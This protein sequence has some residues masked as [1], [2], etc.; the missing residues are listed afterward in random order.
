MAQS[1]PK[2]YPDGADLESRKSQGSQILV[3]LVPYADN[4]WNTAFQEAWASQ[5]LPSC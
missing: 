3:R 4:G 5:L 1:T 2:A